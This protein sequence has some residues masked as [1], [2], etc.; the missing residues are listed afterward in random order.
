MLLFARSEMQTKI[1]Q[2]EHS[3]KEVTEEKI[4]LM[5]KF[6]GLERD[7][8]S[9]SVV[10]GQLKHENE[11]L[12]IQLKSVARDLLEKDR[13]VE[14]KA[15]VVECLEEVLSGVVDQVLES[16]EFGCGVKRFPNACVDAGKA[17]GVH[18]AKELVQGVAIWKIFL[19]YRWIV[20]LLWMRL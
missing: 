18:E 14:E 5:G 7:K 16:K 19:K 20:R 9:L 10:V 15:G 12:S 17:L 13:P 6:M 4:V 8:V 2:L 1:A 11:G 3:L